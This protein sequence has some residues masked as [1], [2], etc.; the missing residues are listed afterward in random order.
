MRLSTHNLRE[1]T[2]CRSVGEFE[3]DI[4]YKTGSRKQPAGWPKKTATKEACCAACKAAVGCGAGV[5]GPP[6]PDG[7][8]WFKTIDE[9][10]SGKGKPFGNKKTIG[11]TLGD[12]DDTPPAERAVSGTVDA[13]FSVAIVYLLV[14]SVYNQ[15]YLKRRGWEVVPHATHFKHISELVVEGVKFSYAKISGKKGAGPVPTERTALL[16]SRSV[17]RRGSQA[18]QASRVSRQSDGSAKEQRNDSRKAKSASK[19][20]KKEK[21]P[22]VKSSKSKSS[23]GERGEPTPL[24]DLPASPETAVEKQQRLLQEQAVADPAVHSSQQKIKVVSLSQSVTL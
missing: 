14:M 16:E 15:K 24:A 7:E 19:K 22:K 5:W 18:S 23:K 6:G 9:V 13:L 20:E 10:K 8:C 2:P 4:D 12:S 11:C 1:E 3:N 17:E 21:S